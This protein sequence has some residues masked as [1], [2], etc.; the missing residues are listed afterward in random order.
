M[1]GSTT[2]QL[3]PYARRGIVNPS[4]L[5]ST[6]NSLENSSIK[7]SPFIKTNTESSANTFSNLKSDKSLFA[8]KDDK[9]LHEN[10]TLNKDQNLFAVPKPLDS[11]KSTASDIVTAGFASDKVSL[12]SSS[13][14]GAGKFVT[15]AV[16]LS[17]SSFAFPND[18]I[19]DTQKLPEN[20]N[21]SWKPAVSFIFFVNFDMLV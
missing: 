16:S 4:N 12:P 15:S 5:I 20:K 6:E 7:A 18:S 9:L 13:T 2:R 10:S 21:S 11:F 8:E 14:F 3:E 19:K 17:Q 1:F